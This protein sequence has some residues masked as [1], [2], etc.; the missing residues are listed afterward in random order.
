MRRATLL[1]IA[2]TR[3]RLVVYNQRSSADRTWL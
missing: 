3:D 2:P 1:G